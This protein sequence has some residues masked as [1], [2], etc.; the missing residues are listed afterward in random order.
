MEKGDERE[1]EREKKIMRQRE[2]LGSAERSTIKILVWS[3]A[4]TVGQ[5]LL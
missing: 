2:D 5:Y 1:R 4:H 3:Q